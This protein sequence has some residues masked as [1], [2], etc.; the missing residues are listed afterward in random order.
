MNIPVLYIYIYIFNSFLHAKHIFIVNMQTYNT[1]MRE[2]VLKAQSS[3]T[4]IPTL[5]GTIIY[6]EM[7][8]Q[9]MLNFIAQ[10]YSTSGIILVLRNIST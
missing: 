3:T 6:I 2:Q 1:C 5:V 10:Y 8:Y 4:I 7:T 9:R